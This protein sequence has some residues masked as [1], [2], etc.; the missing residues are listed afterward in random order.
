MGYTQNLKL[1]V[2]STESSNEKVILPKLCYNKKVLD[3]FSQR[4]R[5]FLNPEKAAQMK[6]KQKEY[7]IKRQQED[8]RKSMHK[9][10]DQARDKQDYRKLM[11]T[12]K[13]FNLVC[14]T[15]TLG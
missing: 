10:I 12:T 11:H 9:E 2:L 3:V 15:S 6:L 4:A 7:D 14:W 8:Y 1:L 13:L 5:R